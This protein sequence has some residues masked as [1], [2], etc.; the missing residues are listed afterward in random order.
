M[1]ILRIIFIVLNL[2]IYAAESSVAEI[3]TDTPKV[4]DSNR[5]YLFYM[6]G[7]WIEM[8]GLH[9]EH[10]QHGLYEYDKIVAALSKRGFVVISEVR[11]R[12]VSMSQYISKVVHQIDYLLNQGVAE[13]D[14]TVIGHSKGGYMT[15][16][17]ASILQK[18]EINFVVMAGCGKQRT[19]FRRGYEKFLKGSARKL[20]GRILSIY[21]IDDQLSA[22]C[23]EAFNVALGVESK[24][25]VFN[26]GKGHGLFY[27]P[28]PSWI[29]EVVKWA[30]M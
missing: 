25:V 13:K 8:K 4:V 26:T 19:M 2:M 15:L 18:E 24:E 14:I 16:K 3:Y 22:S 21:G 5:K 30:G 10:P 12:R 9:K 1:S 7:A 20:N 28:E 27:S 6:H 11:G 23:Q 17:V 29:D